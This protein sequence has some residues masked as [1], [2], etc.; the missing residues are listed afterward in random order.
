MNAAVICVWL[1]V[2]GVVSSASSQP[3]ESVDGFV[4]RSYTGATG[5]TLPYRLFIPDA[6]VRSRPVPL[7]VYL[8]GSGGAGNDNVRQISGGNTA[9]TRLWAT[10][11][12][13]AR[14]PAFVLAPQIPGGRSWSAPSSDAPAPY[15]QLMLDLLAALSKEFAIDADRIYVT[16][17]SLGGRGAWTLSASGPISSRPRFRYAVMEI[18]RV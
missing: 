4:A 15:A 18:P 16:G 2:L 6:A 7:I 1:A 5:T 12:V 10:A 9:G 8:H 14:H 3:Q 17:Q 13:Q 11:A